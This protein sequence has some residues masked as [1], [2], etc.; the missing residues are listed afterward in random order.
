M[1]PKPNLAILTAEFER[2]VNGLVVGLVDGKLTLAQF[3]TEMRL[4]IKQ[5]H[6]AAAALANGGTLPADTKTV[7]AVIDTQL[8]YFDRWVS[9]L[10]LGTLPP[11]GLAALLEQ[12]AQAER[13][14][15]PDNPGAGL[16]LIGGVT[17]LLSA[18]RNQIA[19]ESVKAL[20][21]R[22]RSYGKAAA[23]TSSRQQAVNLGLPDMPFYPADQTQCGN[24]DLCDWDFVTLTGNGNVDCYWRLNVY[25]DTSEHCP[26]CL[27]RHAAANPLRVRNGKILN[28]A[29][30]Q[31]ANLYY[32]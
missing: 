22:A 26:T 11:E 24:N 19:P 2:I 25:G 18:R 16:A 1:T 15:Q 31:A 27:A 5:H 20:S 14:K 7:Q 32:P 13:Q 29:R 3:D 4:A 21:A 12:Y 6:L 8:R 10:Y 30:Y 23:Q 17:S 28:E 9:G